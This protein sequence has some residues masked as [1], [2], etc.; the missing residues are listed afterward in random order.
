MREFS[1]GDGPETTSR[2]VQI[3]PGG[4]A[5]FPC[6]FLREYRAENAAGEVLPVTVSCPTRQAVV[7]TEPDL[8]AAT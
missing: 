5:A 4:E 3:E 7:V 6:G 1:F 8:H 2:V